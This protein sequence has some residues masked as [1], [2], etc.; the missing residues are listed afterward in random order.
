[1]AREV[2]ASAE[3]DARTQAS[4]MV[5]QHGR[6]HAEVL[7]WEYSDRSKANDDKPRYEAWQAVIRNIV[8]HTEHPPQPDEQRVSFG[9][10]GAIALVDDG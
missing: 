1:M 10:G 6:R 9:A 7:A 2:P 4:Q 8:D 5:R 3:V